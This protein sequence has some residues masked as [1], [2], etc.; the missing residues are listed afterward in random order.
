MTD[1]LLVTMKSVFIEW[2]RLLIQIS[3]QIALKVV[4]DGF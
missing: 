4:S 3:I 2:T 1:V